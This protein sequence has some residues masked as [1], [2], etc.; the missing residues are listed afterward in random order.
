MVLLQARCHG[1]RS[2]LCMARTQKPSIP[3]VVEQYTRAQCPV[4]QPCGL[5]CCPSG[6]ASCCRQTRPQSVGCVFGMPLLACRLRKGNRGQGQVPRAGKTPCN[7]QRRPTTN[8]TWSL[9]PCSCA[10]VNHTHQAVCTV[11]TER[12]APFTQRLPF[13]S[14]QKLLLARTNPRLLQRESNKPLS[15]PQDANWGW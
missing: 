9:H 11:C 6:S 4:N 3:L 12:H 8:C 2:T 13:S 5:E 1:R 15:C 14:L 10:H 7:W